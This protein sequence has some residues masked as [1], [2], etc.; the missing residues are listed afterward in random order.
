[1]TGKERRL[2]ELDYRRQQLIA[3]L[4]S[5]EDHAADR[6]SDG[7]YGNISRTRMLIDQIDD[8]VAWFVGKMP[9]P[10]RP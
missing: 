7:E 3:R 10:I 8:E 5:M 9:R 2:A 1:M 6:P 4:R